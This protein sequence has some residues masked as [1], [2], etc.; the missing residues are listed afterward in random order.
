MAEYDEALP[1]RLRAKQ[2]EHLRQGFHGLF[3]RMPQLKLEVSPASLVMNF[4]DIEQCAARCVRQTDFDCRSF[5]VDNRARTCRLYNMTH[6]EGEA[7]LRESAVTDHYRTAFEKKFNKLPN[8]ILTLQHKRKIPSISV[9][10][11]ARRC[12]FEQ[13]FRCAGFDYEPGY[14]NCW[15]TDR[16]VAEGG[17]KFHTGADFYERDFGGALSNFI[18]FGHGSL[19]YVDDRTVYESTM[20]HLDLGACA[21]VCLSQKNFVCASFDYVFGERS[22]HMSRYVASTVGGLQNETMPTHRV[23]HYEKK[24]K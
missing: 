19:P 3:A 10:E 16:T 24:G 23:M 2:D 20:F 11:C 18:S 13:S 6:T 9:E 7:Y 8:H 15:L 4:S 14:A 22:C 5:D 17:V 12:L 1:K 21:Q